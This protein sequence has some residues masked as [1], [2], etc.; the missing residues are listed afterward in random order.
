[1]PRKT[2]KLFGPLDWLLTAR[3]TPARV[4]RWHRFTRWEVR[5][6]LAS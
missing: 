3:W 2:K 5:R 1:M 6:E 4:R